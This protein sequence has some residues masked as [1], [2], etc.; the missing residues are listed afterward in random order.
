L[1]LIDAIIF[2]LER[3]QNRIFQSKALQALRTNQISDPSSNLKSSPTIPT[4]T[5]TT[6]T[7]ISEDNVQSTDLEKLDTISTKTINIV[8]EL[9]SVQCRSWRLQ[10]VPTDFYDRDLEYR[11]TTILSAPSPKSLCKSL[12]MKNTKC[13]RDDCNDPLNSKYYLVM[14]PYTE[15]MKQQKLN[16]F[17]KSLGKKSNKYYKFTF[18]SLEETRT[19]TGFEYN[20]VSPIGIGNIPI[21]LSHHIEEHKDIWIGSGSLDVKLRIDTAEFLQ[22]WTPFV[23]DITA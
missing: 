10:I 21:I 18:A 15:K 1:A 19:M 11:A 6:T 8:K 12:L 22:K 4:T 17:V 7:V 20:T 5:T 3:A 16:K 2:S 9:R 13:I 23:A 14:V